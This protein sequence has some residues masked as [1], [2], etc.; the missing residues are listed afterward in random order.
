MLLTNTY[1]FHNVQYESIMTFTSI[2]SVHVDTE[3][4]TADTGVQLALIDVI[5]DVWTD[6]SVTFVGA[7]LFVLLW[8]WREGVRKAKVIN[9]V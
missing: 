4:L 1:L 8:W 6:R 9:Q 7:Q 5:K 2:R 3:S